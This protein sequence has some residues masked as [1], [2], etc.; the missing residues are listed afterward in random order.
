[1]VEKEG[2]PLP[3]ALDRGQDLAS[4][5]SHGRSGELALPDGSGGLAKPWPM[6]AYRA[7]TSLKSWNDN[8]SP[9]MDL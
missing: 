3:L 1:M 2:Q 8:R 5:A 4:R 9:G 7:P 6:P